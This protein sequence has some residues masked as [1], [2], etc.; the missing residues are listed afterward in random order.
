[1]LTP[2]IEAEIAALAA[3]YGSPRRVEARLSGAPFDPLI[4]TDRFGEVCMA[5]RRPSGTL[6]TAIKTFY[7]PGAYRLLTG[8]V[9]HGESVEAGLLREVEEETGLEV[10][11]RQFLAVIEYH[12]DGRWEMGDGG[13]QIPSSHPPSPS[14]YRFVTFVFL[15]DEVGGM[16]GPSDPEERIE[17]FREIAVAE[18]P[19]LAA[20]LERI[21]QG[22]DP[23]IAGSWGD[24]GRFRAIVH[25]VVYE[26]L[27]G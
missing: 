21:G 14:P 7:P 27:A 15:L 6:L 1:M 4:M 22:F 9:R 18:L 25:R 5:I 20:T 17:S 24:W 19:E 11:V 8:G 13:W 3:R 2:E 10:V 26:E 12:L 23:Q 16:L